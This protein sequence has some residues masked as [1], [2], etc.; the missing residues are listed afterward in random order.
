MR[1]P[2]SF[3]F[4]AYSAPADATACSACGRHKNEETAFTDVWGS[5]HRKLYTVE[6]IFL[7]HAPS[8]QSGGTRDAV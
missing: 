7:S 1:S 2:F 8:G 5:D 3:A 4:T 6:C